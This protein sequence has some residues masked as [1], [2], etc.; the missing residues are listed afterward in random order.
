MPR[1]IT[2]WSTD[3]PRL[4]EM[5]RSIAEEPEHSV[6]RQELEAALH[7][8]QARFCWARADRMR[9]RAREDEARARRRAERKAATNQ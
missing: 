8:M 4:A 5:L 2:E 9:A 3:D 1:L 6:E 7:M